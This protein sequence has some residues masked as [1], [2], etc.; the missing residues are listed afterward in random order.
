MTRNHTRI[1]PTVWLFFGCLLPVL[2]GCTK[3]QTDIGLGLRPP[4]DSLQ[5]RVID[6]STV[7]FQTVREDSLETDELSTGLLGQMHLPGFSQVTAGLVTQLRLSATD[8]S[9]GV[10]PVADSMFLQLRYTGDAYGRLLP[11][12]LSV[13]PLSDSLSLDSNYFS[14]FTV[15]TTGDEWVENGAGPWPFE[16]TSD[17]YV[18]DDT[19][20]PQLRLP[21]TL[22]A[23]QSILDLDS[24]AFDNNAAWF[25]I[26][27]GIAIQHA[28]GGHGIAALDINSG[29][30]VMRLHYHNDNDTAFYDFLISPLSARV[31][32][33]KHHFTQDLADFNNPNV[34]ELSGAVRSHV[35]AASGCKTRVT[36][37]HLAALVDSTGPS[38]T[39]LKAE[40]T[41][42]VESDWGLKPGNPQDQLFVFLERENGTFGSTPDQ[43]APIPIGGE[44]DATQNA[45]VFNM[46]STVHQFVQGDLVGRNLYL[47]SN[48]AG[49]SVAGVV[50]HG[51]EHDTPAKLTITLGI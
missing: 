35:V 1:H 17:I 25:D 39:I 15:Q 47:V 30:S 7:V 26:V 31:N 49:I 44:Y 45:Y 6:T 51:P 9:F 34:T 5:V 22:D 2:W 18:G 14:N 28:G 37:P 8:I 46:T 16:P 42:P 11:Q 19:L 10:N 38:P 48:R 50:L 24:N 20:A 29:L 41:V 3:P 32:V 13:Q 36:F 40:L 12:D 4:T 43:N 33:F 23:A 27:P 21:L